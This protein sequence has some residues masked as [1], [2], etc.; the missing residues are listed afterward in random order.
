MTPT[1]PTTATTNASV[2]ASAA[3]KAEMPAVASAKAGLRKTLAE[4]RTVR[5]AD[6]IGVTRDEAWALARMAGVAVVIATLAL[7]AL[8]VRVWSDGLT[9]DI[10]FHIAQRLAA[11]KNHDR[12]QL[13]LAARRSNEHLGRAATAMGLVTPD[14]A[15][16]V[17]IAPS[18]DLA[19]ATASA[20]EGGL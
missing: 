13:D 20:G 8:T 7:G 19:H 17:V 4:M 5:L 9:K 6:Q 2:P 3:P 12:L 14:R 10:R 1:A 18:A 16:R 15:V 11:E